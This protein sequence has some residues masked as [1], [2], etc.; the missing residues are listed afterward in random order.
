MKAVEIYK[1]GGPEELKYDE[2]PKPEINPDDVLVKIYASGVNPVDYKVR[3]GD[4]RYGGFFPRIL[5]WDFSGVIE[6]TG[7]K[8]YDWKPGDAVYG[9]PDI[10]RNGTYAEYVAVRAD[11][12]AR[13]PE[14]I[15]HQAASG[16]ALAGLTAWQALFTHG[17]LQPE[18]RMILLSTTLRAVRSAGL[19]AISVSPNSIIFAAS[20]R[21]SARSRAQR[22]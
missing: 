15:D 19:R 17:N 21:S 1:N 13:K 20:S 16:V 12:I 11:Q 7:S 4:G 10:T 5:G 22:G 14:S 18:W 9:R 8:V 3:K 6:Q 2:T